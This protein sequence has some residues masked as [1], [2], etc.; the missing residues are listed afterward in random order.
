MTLSA[1]YKPSHTR[2]VCID[3]DGCAFDTMEIKHKE[4]F[5]PATIHVWGLQPVAKYARE[6]WEFVNLYSVHRGRSRFH[7]LISMFDLLA[8]REEV[9]HRGYIPQDIESFRRWVETA[10]VLNNDALRIQAETGDPV[11]G[12]ALEWSLEINRRVAEMVYGIPPFPGVRE[13]LARLSKEADV[14]IVSATPREALERE[15]HEHGLMEYV[16]RLCAQEDGTKYECIAGM[17]SH[18]APTS[19]LMIGDAPG[20]LEA[21]RRNGVL[22]YPIR[23][24]DE[25][26]SWQE[27]YDE[28]LDRFLE[29][30]F[31]GSY[32][33]AQIQRFELCLPSVPP[34]QC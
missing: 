32:E 22:Y 14:T 23:P 16:H 30:T 19:I 26:R 3:S 11:M 7:V 13:S 25:T 5:C 17:R 10:P 27:F 4:C 8:E 33:Q 6:A 12:R 34:W 29:G 1:Q 31:A 15:W 9:R 18:Y 28:G 21:A 20:D 24:N 2:L